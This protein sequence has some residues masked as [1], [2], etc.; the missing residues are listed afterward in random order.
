[1]YLAVALLAIG[2]VAIAM[3]QWNSDE[4]PVDLIPAPTPAVGTEQ[5]GRL[6]ADR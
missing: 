3:L 2:S 4:A 6:P 1:M 5:V